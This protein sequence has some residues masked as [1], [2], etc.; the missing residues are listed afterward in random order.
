MAIQKLPTL[1]S[2]VG[3]RLT[4]FRLTQRLINLVTKDELKRLTERLG[5]AGQFL[6]QIKQH[7]L[8]FYSTKGQGDVFPMHDSSAAV[9][10][11]NA[12]LFSWQSGELSCVLD[13][14][15]RGRTVLSA[16][17]EKMISERCSAVGPIK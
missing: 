5:D 3:S 11:V 8:E 17:R 12:E 1:F 2:K 6:W 15:Q 9:A 4:W 13:D 7:Y 10:M 14:E 16:D